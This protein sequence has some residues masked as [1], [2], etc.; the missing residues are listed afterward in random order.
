MLGQIRQ[1]KYSYACE[2]I[3]LVFFFKHN[4]FFDQVKITCNVAEK[5]LTFL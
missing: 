5:T 3:L 4:L 1:S 2:V